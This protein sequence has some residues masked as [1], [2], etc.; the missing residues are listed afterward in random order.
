MTTSDESERVAKQSDPE[1]ATARIVE[2]LEK[3]AAAEESLS[4]AAASAGFSVDQAQASL[5]QAAQIIRRNRPSPPAN[6]RFPLLGS[7][8]DWREMT[9]AEALEILA[10]HASNQAPPA[11][12]A[13][14]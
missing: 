4:G 8:L 10:E 9:V 14:A 12:D 7:L 5:R 13:S 6:R 1:Q 3:L 11:T 2:L